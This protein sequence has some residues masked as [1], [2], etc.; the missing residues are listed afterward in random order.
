[1]KPAAAAVDAASAAGPAAAEIHT[2]LSQRLTAIH[3]E[4]QNRWQK[5]IGVLTGK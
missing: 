3:Q 4:R 1:V 2:W 5:I